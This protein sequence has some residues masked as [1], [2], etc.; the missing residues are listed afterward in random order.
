MI[1]SLDDPI[2]KLSN[3]KETILKNLN[4]NINYSF[5]YAYYSINSD[6][7][8]EYGKHKLTV[9]NAVANKLVL[10]VFAVAKREGQYVKLFN[11][12]FGFILESST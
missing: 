6:K 1:Y 3:I 7:V 4:G 5:S 12:I 9:L 10:R 2:L 11:Y 8:I